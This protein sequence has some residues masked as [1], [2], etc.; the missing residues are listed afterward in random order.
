MRILLTRRL[1]IPTLVLAVWVLAS[2]QIVLLAQFMLTGAGVAVIEAQ[3][4]VWGAITGTLADQ[5]DLQTALDGKQ[6]SGTYASGTGSA[7]GTNTGDQTSI[8]GITG[9]VAQFNTAITD[10]DLATGGGTATG[11]NT[12]D[13]TTVSGNAGTATALQTARNI[14]GVSF[15]GTGN[16]TVAAAGSTLSDNIPVSKLNSG[17]SASGSTFWRG[18]ATWASPPTSYLTKVALGGDVTDSSGA[19]TFTDCTGLSFAVTSGTRYN[20]RTTIWYTSAATTTGSKWAI[21]GPATTNMAYKSTYTLTATSVTTNFATAYDIPSSANATSLT[22]GNI[23]IL[24]GTILPSA[25][26]TVIVRFA[27]EL[28]GNAVVCKAGST[29]EWWTP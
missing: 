6:V 26:G 20:F 27:T 22:A 24:E 11:T 14:N 9:T 15:D 5:T 7:N 25:N 4:A 18:D 10:G 2:D 1:A 21:N 28:D 16:I 19:A 13:Q 23:A 17:T 29:L 12:G 8:V 3:A